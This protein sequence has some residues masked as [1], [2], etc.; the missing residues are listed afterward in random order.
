MVGGN[1]VVTQLILNRGDSPGSFGCA[2]CNYKVP[3]TWKRFRRRVSIIEMV[4]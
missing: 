4:L 2:R 1:K 3:S